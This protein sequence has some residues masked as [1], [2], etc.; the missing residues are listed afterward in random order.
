M[1]GWLVRSFLWI[2]IVN[3]SLTCRQISTCKF[4]LKLKRVPLDPIRSQRFSLGMRYFWPSWAGSFSLFNKKFFDYC[5]DSLNEQKREGKCHS[6]DPC[7]VY[8]FELIEL[9]NN[10]NML[11]ESKWKRCASWSNCSAHRMMPCALY[12]SFFAIESE[13]SCF[14]HQIKI[15]IQ[16]CYSF[17]CLCKRQASLVQ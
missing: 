14:L 16:R 8:V 13:I 12:I 11:K 17:L 6:R 10:I 9:Q 5:M 3:V 1:V 2:I 7:I 4:S 15:N